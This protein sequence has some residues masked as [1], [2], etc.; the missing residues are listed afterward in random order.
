[1]MSELHRRNPS[2]IIEAIE[3]RAKCSKCGERKA[4]IP[5]AMTE[6]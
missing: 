2:L 1:M 4:G 6:W 5:E 3:R